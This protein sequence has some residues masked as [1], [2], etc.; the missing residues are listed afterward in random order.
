MLPKI[1]IMKYEGK[2]RHKK[3]GCHYFGVLLLWPQRTIVWPSLFWYVFCHMLPSYHGCFERLKKEIMKWELK[4]FMKRDLELSNE[5]GTKTFW[6]NRTWNFS[7]TLPRVSLLLPTGGPRLPSTVE[8]YLIRNICVFV[9]MLWPTCKV[10]LCVKINLPL[11]NFI[12]TRGLAESELMSSQ[13]NRAGKQYWQMDCVSLMCCQGERYIG[14]SQIC[15]AE[16]MIDM[17]P[18]KKSWTKLI[19]KSSQWD[20]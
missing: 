4:I 12:N 16:S 20:D 8:Y 1:W 10:K 15:M 5:M 17:L 7:S 14:I 13:S 19:D 3:P 9:Y 6:W 11:P 18:W 2:M